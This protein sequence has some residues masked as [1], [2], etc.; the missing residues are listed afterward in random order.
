MSEERFCELCHSQVWFG[1]YG[2]TK[3]HVDFT[4]NEAYE[5]RKKICIDCIKKL[6]S[7]PV[8]KEEPK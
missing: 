3:D 4:T 1:A 8:I 6:N 7:L 2:T 5:S